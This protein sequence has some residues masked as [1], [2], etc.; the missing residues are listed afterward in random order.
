MEEFRRLK[1]NK[2]WNRKTFKKLFKFGNLRIYITW[3]LRLK[4]RNKRD[5]IFGCLKTPRLRRKVWERAQGKCERC[6]KEIDYNVCELHHVLPLARFKEFADDINN[7]QCL[8]HDC[9]KDIHC[10]PFLEAKLIRE[11]CN[12]L[13]LKLED[14]YGNTFKD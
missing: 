12:K 14:Y 13:G 10:N 9:H 6:G 11:R 1:A 3:N 8:C 2:I 7:M 4:A 5:D